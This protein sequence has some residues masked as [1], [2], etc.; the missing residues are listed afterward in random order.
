MH[1]KHHPV[2]DFRMKRKDITDKTW[3]SGSRSGC[4][5]IG[6]SMV[7]LMISIT[8]GLLVMTGVLS[9]YSDLTRSNA[10]LAKMNRQIENGRF[11]IQLLQ[12][13]LWHAGFWDTYTPPQPSLTP[14]TAVP[15]PCLSFSAWDAAYIANMYAIAVQGYADGAGLPAECVGI[16][17]NRQADSDVLV[18]SHASTCVAGDVNCEAYSAA[19]LYIQNQGCS[20][21]LHANYNPAA[22]TD[23]ILGTPGSNL[24]KKDCVTPAD[25]RKIIT[26]IF[27]VRNYS[28][29]VGDGIPTLM[30]AD[31][32]MGGGTVSMQAAQPIIEGVQSLKLQYGRDTSGDGN[33]DIFDDC[34]ACGPVDWANVMAVRVHV[35][36]RS[37]VA[38]TGYSND[39]T[40]N[41]G[42]V[43][44]GPYNDGFTRHAYGT[45]LRLINISGR[46]ETP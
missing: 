13:E 41:L 24:Y 5:Q 19:R 39:K 3:P 30:R 20:N 7:E 46:R 26:S 18:I 38:T 6:F 11:T 31:L 36:A 45:N 9:V 37:L 33:P 27:Y 28:I 15:N 23:P 8:L 21:T 32:D 40:Y 4:H 35:L 29:N 22:V 12:Q 25:R 44:L 2:E 17:T 16:V 43:V 1:S 34:S 14:P 42:G 10:E